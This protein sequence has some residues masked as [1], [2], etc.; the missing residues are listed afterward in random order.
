[1]PQTLSSAALTLQI[2]PASLG[3]AD[4]SEL[5]NTD[6]VWIGQDRAEKAAR[7][8]LAINQPDYNLFVLGEVGSGRSSLLFRVMQ[9]IAATRPPVSDLICLHNFAQPEKPIAL[10]LLP[11]KG[12]V[13][14]SRMEGFTKDI[15]VEIP[16]KLDEEGYRL[17]CARAR[18]VYQAQIDHAYAELAALASS[19]H[20]ALRREDGR[21]VFNL[22]D[23]NGQAMQEETLL[24]MSAEQRVVLEQAE[25]ELRASIGEYLEKIR[26]KERAMEQALADLRHHAVQPLVG[27]LAE[28][29]GAGLAGQQGDEQ[30]LHAWIEQLIDDVLGNLEVFVPTAVAEDAE[31]D[32]LLE[33]LARYRV[34]VVVDNGNVS[35]APVLRDDDPIFR[36]LFGGIEYQA[37]SG[38]LL[39]DFTHIRAGNLVRA[40][41]GFL[42]LHLGDLMRDAQVWEKLQRFLRNGRLQIEEPAAALGQLAA[43]TLEPEAL[44]IQVKIALICTREEYYH[45][46][47]LDPEFCRHFRTKVDFAESFPADETARQ[48]TALFTA[49]TCRRLKLP[50]LEAAAVAR[51]LLDMQREVDDQRR[52]SAVFGRLESW[53]VES[54]TVCTARG[55]ELI[56]VADVEAAAQARIARHNYPEQCLHEAIGEGEIVIDVDGE[57]VGQI[58]GLTQID[59]GDYR[60]GSPVRISAR[61]YAGDEGIINVDREVEM[62]GPNHDKGVFILQHWLAATFTSITPLCLSASLVFEQEYHGVEGDSAS[63][64]ELFALI[65]ALSGLALPQG[66]AVTGALNQHGEVL[67]IGGINE[68]IE[69]YFRICQRLGLNGK[70]GV[71]IPSRNRHHLLLDREVVSAVERGRFTIRTMTN[72]QEGLELLTG[73]AAGSQD[74]MGRFPPDTVLGRVQRTLE[75]F[76]KACDQAEHMRDKE[77]H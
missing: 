5:T 51:L 38:V 72:V 43:T 4:T 32:H 48:A 42:M 69:G 26:P 25:E 3:F 75:R 53:L 16:R 70:Q 10:R 21:L 63:C 73:L 28:G 60:F 29:L 44:D 34:N 13:L 47:E 39:T 45:L 9:E 22:L 52:L 64:A 77:H 1:M 27:R 12:S 7:F 31:H 11:G 46:Q 23:K 54:A 15:T 76:R 37:E 24:S 36:S 30:R 55:G 41:G 49:Q 8:G 56:S 2:D 17:D 6:P 57:R 61:A 65:S 50:H 14:R 68:K 71:I 58:N 35:G 33:L 19:W 66:I 18:K 59:L 67:P 62:S 74:E 40:H 20:Y